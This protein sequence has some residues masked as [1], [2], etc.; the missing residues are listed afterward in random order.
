ME[1]RT[2]VAFVTNLCPYYRRPLFELLARRFDTSF[3]FFSKGN[4]HYLGSA[5]KH[6]PGSLPVREVKRV[7]IAGNPLLI[8]LHRELRPE[9][10]D[11]V[12][13]C[14]NGR[15]MLPYTYHLARHRAIPFVLWSGL[16]RHPETLVHRATRLWTERTY[17]GADAIVTYGEHVKRFVESVPG[18]TAQK[19]YVAGQAIDSRAYAAVTPDFQKPARVLFIGRL[20][21]SKGLRELLSA[22][23]TVKS[24]NTSS[25]LRIVGRGSLEPEV[26]AAASAG[27]GVKALGPLPQTAIPGELARARCLVLP[28]VTTEWGREPWGLVVNEAMAAGVPVI[29]TE[30]VG[31]AAGGL[32][33]DGRNGFVVPER[34]PK[35]LATAISRLVSDPTLASLFGRRARADVAAFD[36]HAM[37]QGFTDAIAH[38]TAV[39]SPQ[40]AAGNTEAS[41][42]TASNGQSA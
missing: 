38:A 11:V 24:G 40:G 29:A 10:Y 2:R 15:L 35:A 41:P 17:R 19:V 13:K 27:T 32:V 26:Q 4:E 23:K 37:L 16:W 25:V 39:R 9:N 20:E 3:F 12:V 6:E 18:V 33:Q 1:R 28:S 21:E 36:Y 22:F 5:L 42:Q 7:V 8:G 14:I 34:N 30:A 31:A